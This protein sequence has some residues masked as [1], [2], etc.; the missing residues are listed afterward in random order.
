MAVNDNGSL[1]HPC[2]L[3]VALHSPDLICLYAAGVVGVAAGVALEDNC[4]P[5]VAFVSWLASV[6]I[7]AADNVVPYSW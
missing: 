1:P 2:Q 6:C 5:A 7:Y 3:W 4:S